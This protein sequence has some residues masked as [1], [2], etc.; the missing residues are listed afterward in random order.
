ML[1]VENDRA[2]LGN[3]DRQRVGHPVELAPGEPR[4]VLEAPQTSGTRCSRG[5]HCRNVPDCISANPLTPVAQGKF[6]AVGYPCN[7]LVDGAS[8]G[9]SLDFSS[10]RARQMRSIAPRDPD[11]E[12]E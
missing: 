12:R 9:E 7:R 8:V 4:D 10:H 2:L 6:D 11:K 3:V 1:F 5:T